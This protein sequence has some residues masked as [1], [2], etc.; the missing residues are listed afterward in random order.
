MTV[1]TMGTDR[2]TAYSQSASIAPSSSPPVMATIRTPVA[3]AAS[4]R[5]RVV[6][7]SGPCASTYTTEV[8][9]EGSVVALS[10]Q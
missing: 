6:G 8:N 2:M 9:R 1:A 10:T 4:Q 5:S 3:P 7:G